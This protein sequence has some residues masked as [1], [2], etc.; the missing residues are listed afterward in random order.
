MADI[1]KIRVKETLLEEKA[2]KTKVTKSKAK[3]T[4]P[5]QKQTKTTKTT[6][7]KQGKVEQNVVVNVSTGKSKGTRQ[8][9]AKKV[10]A[11]ITDNVANRNPLVNTTIN[12]Q[13]ADKNITPEPI[14]YLETKDPRPNVPVAVKT[15]KGQNKY[16]VDTEL[17]QEA[18]EVKPTAK[19]KGLA[20]NVEGQTKIKLQA[21]KTTKLD[22]KVEP[23]TQFVATKAGNTDKSISY[24]IEGEGILE[25]NAEEGMIVKTKKGRKPKYDTA[26]ER[27]EATK[28]MAEERRIKKQLENKGVEL[29]EGYSYGKQKFNQYEPGSTI[30]N[31][32][33]TVLINPELTEKQ[34]SYLYRAKSMMPESEPIF[35]GKTDNSLNKL[36]NAQ[37]ES[38]NNPIKQSLNENVYDFPVEEVP[39][40]VYATSNLDVPNISFV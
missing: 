19:G 14:K 25:S 13:V 15:K 22:A 9:K 6:K 16:D 11:P 21:G 30:D 38:N 36:I 8:S 28:K 26:E 40:L 12:T 39:E 29:S 24:D 37:N 31:P 23:Q 34:K 33:A 17:Q 4:L 2:P 32:T 10:T 27:K 1:Q 20:E 3:K 35:K 5:K 18:F 7:T